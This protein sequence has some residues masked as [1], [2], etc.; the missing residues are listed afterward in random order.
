ME[1]WNAMDNAAA[2]IAQIFANG[3]PVSINKNR[4]GIGTTH[5]EGGTLRMGDDPNNSVTD[6]NGCFHQVK[7]AYA[8]GPMLFTTIGSP[9]PMLTGVALARRMGDHFLP[10][11]LIASPETDYTYLFDGS[12]QQFNKWKK[13]GGGN[14]I[15]NNRTIIAQPF[16]EIGLLYY[17]PEK[18]ENF[19]LKLDFL[20]CR[21]NGANNDNSGVFVRFRDPLLPVPYPN[22]PGTSNPYNNQAFVA[23]DTGFEIQ[24]D[25]EA[26]GDTRFHEPDGLFYN[27]AI[28]KI[29]EQGTNPGQQDY[30]NPQQ[31]SEE[32]WYHYEIEVNGNIYIVR[33]DGQET[34]R[35]ERRTEDKFRGNP[36]GVDPVSGHIG[37]QCHTGNVVF[38][39]IRIK[40]L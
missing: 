34:T 19:I 40:A 10:P 5:H 37:V 16:G 2:Q 31:L 38:A 32:K 15:V 4:D 39:N 33:L 27:R 18:F 35:F 28:Y 11:A 24:I 22:N 17:E 30:R 8:L 25:D 20:L 9:N 7:N 26:R 1:L 29:K 14:F 13:V 23:V 6:A 36:P 12:Q 21:P 3:H